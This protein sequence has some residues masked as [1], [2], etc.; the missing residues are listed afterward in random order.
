MFFRSEEM[1]KRI[2]YNITITLFR[3]LMISELNEFEK[4]LLSKGKLNWEVKI[5]AITSNI[6]EYAQQL[7][8]QRMIEDK[9]GPDDEIL[10][11]KRFLASSIGNFDYFLNR[12]LRQYLEEPG[13][14]QRIQ[15]FANE[16]KTWQNKPEQPYSWQKLAAFILAFPENTH[17]QQGSCEV[18][19]KGL[20][21]FQGIEP[22]WPWDQAWG[23]FGDLYIC[24]HCKNNK[25]LI[26]KIYKNYE[27]TFPRHH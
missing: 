19:G 12:I 11:Q 13:L 22:Y 6:H 2:K 23:H 18:C 1:A 25:L 16:I 14:N 17:F 15:D 27:T 26:L 8:L 9:V 21:A 4:D 10:N 20:V 7:L 3:K 5:R 24:P